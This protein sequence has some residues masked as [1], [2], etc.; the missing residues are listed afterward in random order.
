MQGE[1]PMI[2]LPPTPLTPTPPLTGPAD[3]LDRRELRS[4]DGA[5]E[6]YFHL[7]L[8]QL[9]DLLEGWHLA[10]EQEEG[11]QVVEAPP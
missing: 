8:K 4:D 2:H 6:G 11:L 7:G 3:R 10:V 1:C 5:R 9:E